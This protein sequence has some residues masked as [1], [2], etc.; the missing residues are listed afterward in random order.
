MSKTVH[1]VKNIVAEAT[2][3]MVNVGMKAARDAG[4]TTTDYFADANEFAEECSLRGRPM[5]MESIADDQEGYDEMVA[6]TEDL[7]DAAEFV[8]MVLDRVGKL[9]Q[10]IL[11][12][13]LAG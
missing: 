8:G 11:L 10:P 13:L 12:T 1:E 9:A 5:V 4:L 6:K 2:E 7:V 3:A